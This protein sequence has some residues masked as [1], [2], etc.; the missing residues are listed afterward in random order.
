MTQHLESTLGNLFS[1]LGRAF[2]VTAYLP[3]LLLI[4][5][6]QYALFSPVL[7]GQKVKLYPEITQ[8]ILGFID[9][10][11]LTTLL[12]PIILGLLV[13]SLN[14]LIIRVYEGLFPGARWLL[15]PWLRAKLRQYD[16]L[17]IG[18]IEK[19]SLELRLATDKNNSPETGAKLD[20]LHAEI[21][22]IH[23]DAQ[24]ASNVQ[25]LPRDREMILPTDLGNAFAIIEEY[26]WERYRMDGVLFWSR[27]RPYLDDTLR[28]SVDNQKLVLDL[29][30]SL[31]LT[32]TFIAAE[33]VIFLLLRWFNPGLFLVSVS[34]AILA[35][36]FYRSAVVAV[37]TT[38]LYVCQAYD[39]YR[40]KILADFK[41]EQPPDIHEERRIWLRLATFITRGEPFYFPGKK[42]E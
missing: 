37:R 23:S 5:F 14:S 33:S 39:K 3:M 28:Q 38:G 41:I 20:Q 32:M 4:A 29:Q 9:N 1:H 7:G 22:K 16:R 6:N 10:Q 35:W 30:L 11:L 27:L 21:D 17:Y 12:V 18:L 42:I 24:R 8:P 13:I 40:G 15:S 31:S 19:R 26:P 2:F 25:R 34:A 36:M